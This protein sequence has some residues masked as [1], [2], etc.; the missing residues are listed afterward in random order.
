M[1][2]I[3]SKCFKFNKIIRVNAFNKNICFYFSKKVQ[4]VKEITLKSNYQKE[5]ELMEIDND[6]MIQNKINEPLTKAEKYIQHV[7]KLKEE[8]KEKKKIRDHKMTVAMCGLVLFI[9]LYSLWIP[10]YKTVCESQ[11][12]SVKTT[13][14]D[15]KFT[16]KKCKNNHNFSKCDK[17]IR[18]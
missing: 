11:G 15:Y 5:N 16:G 18:S 9:G 7:Q 3:Y 1:N 13:H 17:E 8:E 12:F 10:L 2:I 4:P 14:T 6:L